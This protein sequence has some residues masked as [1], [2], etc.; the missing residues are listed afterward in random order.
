MA[1]F[2]TLEQLK[3]RVYADDT[4]VYN[5]RLLDILDNAEQ[6]IIT[7]TDHVRED[8]MLIPP[9]AFP[10]E[11]K[12]AILR[13]AATWFAQPEDT[14]PVQYHAVPFGITSLL[15]PYQKLSGGDRLSPIIA[16]YKT[17]ES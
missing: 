17:A 3:A 4:E 10:G 11:L 2:V 15:K 12:E 14:A 13:L 9:S 8:V 6:A 5:E 7:W 1:T 16:R